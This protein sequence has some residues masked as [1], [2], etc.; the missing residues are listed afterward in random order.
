VGRLVALLAVPEGVSEGV[1]VAAASAW[2]AVT[3]GQTLAEALPSMAADRHLACSEA[4][5]CLVVRK[6]WAGAG[7]LTSR[8]VE[9]RVATAAWVGGVGMLGTGVTVTWGRRTGEP[10]GLALACRVTCLRS[11]LCAR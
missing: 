6:A 9:A 2:A 8:P 11:L 10:V 1:A 4:A 3:A 7:L 5:R